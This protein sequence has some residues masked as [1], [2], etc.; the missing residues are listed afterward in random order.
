MTSTVKVLEIFVPEFVGGITRK[1]NC[2]QWS[3]SSAQ[4][5]GSWTCR[6]ED[7]RKAGESEA[8]TGYRHKKP[9]F[10]ALSRIN[11]DE[12]AA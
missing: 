4:L 6:L 7:V 12:R 10:C 2:L 1:Q 8:Y 11:E 9:Y 5:A 3:D